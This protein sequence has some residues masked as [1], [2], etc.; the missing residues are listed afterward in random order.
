MASATVTTAVHCALFPELSIAVSTT[1]LSPILE[2][3]KDET[4]INN[5]EIQ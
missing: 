3:S 4:L 5:S 1:S 2:Q